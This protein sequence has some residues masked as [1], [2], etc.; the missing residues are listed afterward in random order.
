MKKSFQDLV[1]LAILAATSVTCH[2][3]IIQVTENGIPIGSITINVAGAAGGQGV[4]GN[5]QATNAQ[6]ATITLTQLAANFGENHFNWLQFLTPTNAFLGV[7]AGTTFVDPQST[8]QGALWAD[9]F[10][11]YWDEVAPPAML[12]APRT[13]PPTY[14]PAAGHTELGDSSTGNGNSQL[15]FADFPSSGA[16]NTLSFVTCL[17][18]VGPGNFYT[19]V[20]GFSWT[21]TTGGPGTTIS[22]GPTSGCSSLAA[23]QTSLVTNSFPGKFQQAPEPGTLAMLLAGVALMGL[24]R[25]TSQRA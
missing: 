24:S 11:W 17:V 6:G 3:A 14:I 12:P 16:A 21:A 5:F 8:G 1:H 23:A 9:T 18:S 13:T 19:P 25:K 4:S 2:A 20:G 15:S 7:A 22:A 10:P